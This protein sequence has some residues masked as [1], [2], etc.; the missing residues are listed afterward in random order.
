[1]IADANFQKLKEKLRVE[2]I[3]KFKFPKNEYDLKKI[4]FQK[5]IL[6]NVYD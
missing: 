4:H 1:M 6:D 5:V 3:L 2:I